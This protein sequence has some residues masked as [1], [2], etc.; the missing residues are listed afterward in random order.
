MKTV[1]T[2]IALSIGFAS[3]SAFAQSTDEELQPRFKRP[4]IVSKQDTTPQNAAAKSPYSY[5]TETSPN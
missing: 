2:V 1:A 4:Q 5:L 3:A